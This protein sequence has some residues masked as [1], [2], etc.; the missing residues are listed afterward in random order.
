LGAKGSCLLGGNAATNAGGKYYV[1]YGS[2]RANILGMEVVT[3]EG[4]LLDML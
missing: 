1:K 4:E 2:L 3:G